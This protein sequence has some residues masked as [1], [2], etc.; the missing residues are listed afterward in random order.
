MKTIYY[1]LLLDCSYSMEP[2][3]ELISSQARTHLQR[4]QE[5]LST[6]NASDSLFLSR[7]IAIPSPGDFDSFSSTVEPAI[8]QLNT[9]D[10]QGGASLSDTLW[11]L[12]RQIKTTFDT[13]ASQMSTYLLI[14]ITDGWE[15]NA[16]IQP[17]QVKECLVSLQK[18]VDLEIWVVG[19]EH[20][21][22]YESRL[23]P[24]KGLENG[25]LKAEDLNCCFKFIESHLH[26]FLKE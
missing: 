16:T 25:T 7:L 21:V 6:T 8:K 12:L 9:L 15:N 4:L 14:M 13:N 24:V 11:E 20:P 3:W 1:Q 17:W 10:P 19:P 2:A 5:Q 23:L 22:L 26:Q 18:Q